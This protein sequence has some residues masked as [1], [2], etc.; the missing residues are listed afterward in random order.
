[1]FVFIALW[2]MTSCENHHGRYEKGV[3]VQDFESLAHWTWENSL[4][5]EKAHSGRYAAFTG[6]GQEYSQTFAM[7]MSEIYNEGYRHLDVQM[8]LWKQ[9]LNSRV[10]LI[11]EIS[12][13]DSTLV[14]DSYLVRTAVI[15][16]ET[17]GVF[18][19]HKRLRQNLNPNSTLKIYLWSLEHDTAYMD[20]VRIRFS[21]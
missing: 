15:Q 16:P 21:K 20:D 3:Y 12:D 6:A 5:R 4:T 11:M 19:I 18:S 10:R 8:W 17:W 9:T 7:P 2:T 1:M 14:N 13:A